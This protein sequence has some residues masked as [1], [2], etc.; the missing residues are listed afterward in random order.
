MKIDFKKVYFDRI[1]QIEI[2]KKQAI[3]KK[4]W[5]LVAKLEAEKADL[6]KKIDEINTKNKG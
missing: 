3:N 6:L 4:N 2:D 5:S 1:K